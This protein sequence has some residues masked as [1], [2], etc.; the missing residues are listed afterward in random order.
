MRRLLV[1]LVVVL[2]G[3]GLPPIYYAFRPVVP[4]LLPPAG[5]RIA[6]RDGMSVNAIVKGE[7][8]AV[9]LVHG[10]PGSGYDWA[11]LV[12]ALAARGF[13]VIAYDRIGYGRSDARRD[14]DYTIVGNARDLLGLLETRDLHDV[15]LV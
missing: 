1:L 12:D 6:V 7:G 3:L 8:P 2:L 9:V 15:T 5:E 11:P 14:D 10:L 4:P 13:A